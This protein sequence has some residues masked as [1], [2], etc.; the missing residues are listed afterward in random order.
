MESDYGDKLV[1]SLLKIELLST[2]DH[3]DG[4]EYY[5]GKLLSAL[6]VFLLIGQV[7]ARMIRTIVLN[8]TNFKMIVHHI[9]KLKDLRYESLSCL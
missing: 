1:V 5:N 6:V 7:L 9:H 8:D 4:N 2:A 3:I